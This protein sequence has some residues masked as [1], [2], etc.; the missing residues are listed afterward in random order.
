MPMHA[1]A[2]QAKYIHVRSETDFDTGAPGPA[3]VCPPAVACMA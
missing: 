2:E 1:F 3:K